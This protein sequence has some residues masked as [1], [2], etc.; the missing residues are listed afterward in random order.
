MILKK[1]NYFFQA[2]TSFFLGVHYF[3]IKV[4]FL[5]AAIHFFPISGHYYYCHSID[6]G[7]SS[8]TMGGPPPNIASFFREK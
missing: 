3:L 7:K 2:I 1:D 4:H 5:M 6:L 8:R